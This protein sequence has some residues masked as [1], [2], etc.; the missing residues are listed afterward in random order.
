MKL[1]TK[2]RV[3]ERSIGLEAATSKR[4]RGTAISEASC[5][6]RK[7]RESC[8]SVHCCD[9]YL[10]KYSSFVSCNGWSVLHKFIVNQNLSFTAPFDIHGN[11]IYLEHIE[12][13]E[14]SGS[15]NE[16]SASVYCS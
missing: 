3:V 7:A 13:S 5:N 4:T 11:G 2:L 10:C 1:L 14:G 15:G 8:P 9:H 16:Y 6:C 12:L